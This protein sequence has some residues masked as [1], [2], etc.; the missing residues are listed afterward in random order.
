MLRFG[1]YEVVEE[2]GRGGMG[3]VYRGFDP[4]IRRYVAL[5]TIKLHDI[6]EPTERRSMQERLER[7]AQSA[8]RLSHPNIVTIYQVGYA[9]LRPGETTAFIAMELIRG[10]SLAEVIGEVRTDPHLMVALLEQA[11]SALDHA[12]RQGVIHRDV[13]P[14][15][16]LVTAE[17]QIKVTDF[18]VA[19][20]V[21][22]TI[23]TTGTVLGSPF[24]MSPEQIKSEP[25]DGRTDQ[26]SL[27]VV[28]YEILSGAKPFQAESLSSLVFQIV[29]QQPPRLRMEPPAFAERVNA[30]L[31]RAMAKD[32][33]Q[34]FDTCTAFVSALAAALNHGA[35]ARGPEGET[36]KET[37]AAAIRPEPCLAPAAPASRGPRS[38]RPAALL[39]MVALVAVAYY[40]WLRWPQR[41]HGPAWEPPAVAEPVGK[42][43]AARPRVD[44]AGSRPTPS[45][46]VG[47]ASR[48]AGPDAGE[49]ST[50]PPV[51]EP[52]PAPQVAPASDPALAEHRPNTPLSPPGPEAPGG[53]GKQVTPAA[54][55]A[56]EPFLAQEPEP[57]AG[58]DGAPSPGGVA[59]APVRKAPRVLRETPAAYTQEAL[60]SGIEGVVVLAVDID[61]RGIPRTARVI[62][63]LDQGLD[64]QAIQSLAGWRFAPATVD[65]VP[66]AST[67]NV[68]IVFRLPQRAP[69]R[70]LSLKKP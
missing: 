59:P 70:P 56:T 35:G 12:H 45:R 66:A 11:A 5:K 23:T 40:A 37:V 21:S 68:E 1:Q 26:Y 34:R 33:A 65:G 44:P 61:E 36:E 50:P 10:R 41:P 30:V 57:P 39:G 22:H 69:R 24:Y 49:K 62:R 9:E 16:L 38:Y 31:L 48:P 4:V 52:A 13:K 7:E 63:S 6:G 8:G 15:N 43:P 58:S 14:A 28:A 42:P 27:A 64:Q 55:P 47:E 20:I 2:I 3:V 67:A 60:R 29:Q 53:A 32:P 18:G 19:K 25:V 46:S 54:S 17:G 51:P